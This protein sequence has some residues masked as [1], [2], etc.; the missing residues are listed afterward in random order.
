[1][2]QLKTREQVLADFERHGVTISGWAR[3]HGLPRNIVQDVLCGKSRARYGKGHKAAVLLGLKDGVI[4][5][6]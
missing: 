5:K 1:M 6:D 3:E 2:K 4:A